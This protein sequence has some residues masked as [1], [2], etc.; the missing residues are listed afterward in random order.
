VIDTRKASAIA[1]S[2]NVDTIIQIDDEIVF[3]AKHEDRDDVDRALARLGLCWSERV[4]L[5]RVSVLG[6]GMKS[7]PGVAPDIFAVVRDLGL[8]AEFVSTS[9]ITISFYVPSGDAAAVVQTL[10]ARLRPGQRS[11]FGGTAA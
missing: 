11:W 3:S 9:P 4:D 10:H 1:A 8:Q 6:G 7:H 5:A 2:V